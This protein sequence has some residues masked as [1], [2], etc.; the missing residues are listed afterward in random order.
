MCVQPIRLSICPPLVE[1][2]GGSV[3]ILSPERAEA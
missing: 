3:E 2:S 1:A